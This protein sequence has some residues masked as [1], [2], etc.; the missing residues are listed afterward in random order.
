[1][2][3]VTDVLSDGRKS[4]RSFL[5]GAPSV[6]ALVQS[7]QSTFETAHCILPSTAVVDEEV[8]LTVLAWDR[9]ERLVEDCTAVLEC[10]CT[11]SE[12][13][14]PGSMTF[15]G[16]GGKTTARVSFATPGVH[17][18]RLRH[19]ETDA[20]FVSNPIEVT[21]RRPEYDLYWGDIHFHSRLSDGVGSVRKGFEYGRDV[22]QLDVV[23]CTDHDTMGF[24]IP[25]SLQL[26]R[27][28]RRNFQRIK[29]AV[30]ESHDPGSFVTLFGYEWTK[31]PNVGGHINVYFDTVD[32]AELFDSHGR[33][34]A[35]YEG[36]WRRLR[37]WKEETGHDVLTIPHHPAEDMYPFDFSETEYDDEMAPLVEV[38][39]QWGSSELSG[40]DGNPVPIGGIGNGEVGRPGHYVQDALRLGNRV[41]MIASSDIHG[42]HPGHSY[43][44]TPPHLPKLSE[45][46]TDGLGW[47]FIWRMWDEKS[48]PG[49]LVAFYAP[50]LSREAIFRSLKRRQV[51]GTTQP[52]RISISFAINDTRLRDGESRIVVDAPS[53]ERQV[54][55]RVAGTAPLERV[56]VL[57]NN[58]VW[59]TY[60]QTPSD[61][62]SFERYTMDEQFSDE[63]PVCGMAWDERRNTGDDTYYVRVRQTDGGMGWAGPMWVAA[64]EN[65]AGAA[66]RTE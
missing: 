13:T 49:G 2:S 66:G 31:Q 61:S 47:G 26:R 6:R 23:A 19:P 46:L 1:M 45:V 60:E 16:R 55:V 27:M 20:T 48:Y 25:P 8:Q 15:D 58:D 65:V 9:Y 43:I 33:D 7:R 57:K 22:M 50:E 30:A 18:V 3:N 42:P 54:S 36:L 21:E 40:E 5:R 11:D 12:A 41:G 53:A 17:Y 51:Y 24:F 63:T 32:D 38:Y 64:A 56:E 39:S 62:D 28:R 4:V 14:V 29:D 37:R 34:T 44:H 35:T 10:E 59:R 52:S